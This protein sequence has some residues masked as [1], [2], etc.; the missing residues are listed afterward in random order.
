M[1]RNNNIC[2]LDAS[3][4]SQPLIVRH[5]QEGDRIRPFGMRGSKLLSDLYTDLK[6][7]RMEKQQQWVLC[8]DNRIVWAIVLRTSELFRLHGNEREVLIIECCK[9]KIEETT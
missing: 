3:R 7:S 8:H 9:P 2:V 6:L 1:P 4:L 5:P